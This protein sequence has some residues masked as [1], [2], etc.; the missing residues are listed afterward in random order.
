MGLNQIAKRQRLE[1]FKNDV[2]SLKSDV[3]K[4]R[5]G[6]PYR[7]SSKSDKITKAQRLLKRRGGEIAEGKL[8][9]IYFDKVT[10]NQLADDFLTDYRINE[11]DT[12][13]KAERSVK[14]LKKMFG[15]LKQQISARIR[16]GITSIKESVKVSLMPLS[17]EN[18][19]R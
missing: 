17:I 3:T 12:L 2:E 15:V 7:E 9:E 6:K 5:Y 18:S 19:Q 10:F 16:L 1:E 14:Y 13:T 11:R 8:P 4:Y